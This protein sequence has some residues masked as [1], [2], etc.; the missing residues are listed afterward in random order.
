MHFDRPSFRVQCIHRMDSL[1]IEE[2]V[3]VDEQNNV[4]GTTNK[5]DVHGAKTP[6]HRGFSLFLFNGKGEVLLQ[7]R[8]ATKQT[9]PLVWSNSVCGH[10]GNGES[11][12]DAAARR[13]LHELG[14]KAAKIEEVAEYRYTFVRDGVMENEICPILVGFTEDEPKP[15]PSEVAATR[16]VKWEEFLKE[17]KERPGT[18]S[19]WCE[20]EARILSEGNFVKGPLFA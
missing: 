10:P 5:S 14:M 16:W 1:T 8:S 9:W 17:I 20:E 3:L 6:L 2:V 18:Y 19:E 12:I 13:L 11:N 4:L 7:Q 15:N